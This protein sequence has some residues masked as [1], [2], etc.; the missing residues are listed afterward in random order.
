MK[1]SNYSQYTQFNKAYI[2][3]KNIK[4][5]CSLIETQKCLRI[6]K[7]IV[8]FDS[9][10]V[11]CFVRRTLIFRA[12]L[13]NDW[14]HR[15]VL[16]SKNVFLS[17]LS[18]FAVSRQKLRRRP[19][20]NVYG[21]EKMNQTLHEGTSDV[22]RPRGRLREF[23]CLQSNLMVYLVF[24]FFTASTPIS[25]NFL[26]FLKMSWIFFPF[27]RCFTMQA[28]NKSCYSSCF[29]K[30]IATYSSYGCLQVFLSDGRCWRCAFLALLTNLEIYWVLWGLVETCQRGES[31]GW[32]MVRLW[33][34][35]S[36][37]YSYGNAS[38][39]SRW[40][41]QTVS[42]TVLSAYWWRPVFIFFIPLYWVC[43]TW[44]KRKR[45]S[46][47]A[48]P[49]TLVRRIL[50]CNLGVGRRIHQLPRLVHSELDW[51]GNNGLKLGPEM[52]LL[53][54]TNDFS[55]Q[56][57]PT[58]LCVPNL[59]KIYCAFSDN[60]KSSSFQ[61]LLRELISHWKKVE[62]VQLIEAEPTTQRLT[63]G[64]SWRFCWNA[65]SLV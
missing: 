60:G 63:D 30:F 16:P 5:E 36:D 15:S 34:L 37:D 44:L 53:M 48:A 62:Y 21:G 7:N 39:H 57:C 14:S 58:S 1:R 61:V 22:Y 12:Y 41:L 8:W 42:S 40:W 18:Q 52:N 49:V 23:R 46:L 17:S 4:H 10:G 50:I 64:D 51:P 9:V 43:R 3:F 13:P 11:F 24:L 28:A 54:V 31:K 26:G 25:I 65:C 6:L 19:S 27:G 29:S 38:T 2:Q 45:A 33:S 32:S 35:F 47:G 55:L 56:P 20:L 59:N